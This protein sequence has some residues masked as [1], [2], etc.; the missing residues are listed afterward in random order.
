MG[1]LI[2]E[3]YRRLNEK[4]HETRKYGRWGYR[5]ATPVSSLYVRYSC[6]D[7]LDYGAGQ[8]SLSK[9]VP[10]PMKNYDP[11]IAE[12]SGAPSPADLVVCSDVLEHIEPELLDNVLQDIQRVTKIVAYLVIAT[13]LDGTKTL[14][15][16]RDPHL[17]V[18]PSEWWLEKVGDYFNVQKWEV[19]DRQEVVIEAIPLEQTIT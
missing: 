1:E 14:P 17:I 5:Q 16:G 15:D 19:G 4:L 6:S 8:G 9:S 3:D 11:A 18:K 13:T 10:F 12:I 2:S 7:A